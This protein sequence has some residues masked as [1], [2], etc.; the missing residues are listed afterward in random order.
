LPAPGWI[1]VRPYA[2]DD[3]LNF[4]AMKWTSIWPRNPNNSFSVNITG[5]T[6]S[7]PW[8][9]FTQRSIDKPIMEIVSIFYC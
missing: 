9:G 5:V 1:S 8:I 2:L 3:T 7:R 6:C 4:S